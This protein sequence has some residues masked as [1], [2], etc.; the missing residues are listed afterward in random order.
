M[1]IQLAIAPAKRF[2]PIFRI[3]V[4]KLGKINKKKNKNK[5]PNCLR[6]IL[7]NSRK[8]IYYNCNKKSYFAKSYP[9]FLKN[10]F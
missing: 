6:R 9:E 8:S 4:A 10:E 5:N 7:H 3:N 2:S 1:L